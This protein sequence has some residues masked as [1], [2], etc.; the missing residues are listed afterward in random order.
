M[1]ANVD[2][3]RLVVVVAAFLA[4]QV[5]NLIV[6][7]VL[8]RYEDVISPSVFLVAGRILGVLLVAF[9]TAIVIDGLEL[10]EV[11]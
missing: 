4:V 1:I 5:F 7:L 10:L 8:A 6:F 3:V 11:I 2:N 9:G